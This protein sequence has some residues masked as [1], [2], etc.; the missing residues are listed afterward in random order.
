LKVV[1]IVTWVKGQVPVQVE[2]E[3]AARHQVE[4]KRG[5]GREVDVMVM[6]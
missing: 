2:E 6:E 1:V 3:V 4:T 5:R